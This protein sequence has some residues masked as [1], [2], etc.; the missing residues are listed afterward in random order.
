MKLN[1]FKSQNCKIFLGKEACDP[2][3]RKYLW[4]L[5]HKGPEIKHF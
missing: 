4:I 3:N 2:K 1:I 5:N